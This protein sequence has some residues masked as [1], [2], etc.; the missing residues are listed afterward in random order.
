MASRDPAAR[1]ICAAIAVAD[2]HAASL[3]HLALEPWRLWATSIRDARAWT[4]RGRKPAGSTIPSRWP[5][6]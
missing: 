6:C 5:L 4:R 2:P 3:C 1:A